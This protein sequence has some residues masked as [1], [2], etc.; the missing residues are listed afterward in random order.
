MSAASYAP[1]RRD[2]L[3]SEFI[4]NKSSHG[5]NQEVSFKPSDGEPL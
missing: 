5:K 3:A 2:N 4:N 1:Y